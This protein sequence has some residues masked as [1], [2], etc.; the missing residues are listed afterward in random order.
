MPWNL[1]TLREVDKDYF[2]ELILDLIK[3]LGFRDADKIATSEETGADIIAIR[4]DPVSGLE[5]YLIKIKPRSLV[6]SS[7][8]NDFI[9]VLDRYKGDRG[10]FVTNVDFTKD[11]KLLAQREHRGRLIL[12]SGGKVVEMLN[13]YRIEPKKELIEKLKSK[14][15]AESKKR[16]I[17]KIIKLDSPLLFDFNHEKTVE[18]VIGKLSKEY[19]IKRALVSLKYLGVILSPAYIISWSCRTKEQKEAEIKD[20]AVVF[21]DGSIVIRTSEDER[22]KPTVS[23]ALLNNSSVIKCTEKTLEVGISPSEATLIAKSQLSKELNVSQSHIAISAKKKVYVPKKALLKLQIHKNEAEAEMDLETSEIKIK[24]SL[25]PEEMLVD[26][27]KEE[28]KRVTREELREYR[29]KIKEN[30]MLLRGETERFEFAVAIDGYTGEILAKDIRMKGEALLEL[31]SQLY[32]QGKLV[33][34]EERKREAVGDILVE[35]KIVILK[36]N[37]ENGEYSVLKELHH[38]E[39]AFKAAK[40]IIEDNFPVKDL[41]LENFKVLGHKVIEVLLSGEGGKARVKVDGTNLDVIDYFVEINQNKAKEL[42]LDKYKGCK[43]EEISED[44][45]SF[46]FSVS[47]D[48]QKIRVKISKDGK[49]I[50]ELDNVMKE[51]VVRE[52]ALKYLEEQG[53]EAKIEEITLDTDWIITFIG[54]EKFGKLILGRADGKVKAQE[55]SY[56]ERALEKFYYEHL[57]QKYGEENPATERMTHYRDKGYLTIKVSSEKKLYYAKI[58]VKTGRIIA[59]DTLVDKGITAKI[60]KMRLESRYK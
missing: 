32:P 46:T 12:W 24:I 34:V 53:V 3:N 9:R 18:K 25:L 58:D 10:I 45:D 31:I 2:I 51:E 38:P 40:A 60:K 14:K 50:E 28:C 22:L 42:I 20:K 54:D 30:R 6:S 8:L 33:N 39:E 52:K 15:E 19:K 13:E 55:I 4:E 41:K 57:K 35:N 59:E 21:S 56:T 7:D 49:L 37:L 29:T 36:V 17:L 5:K 11:A 1:E 16:A 48:T 27:A 43:I 23:K 44:S 47:S 26:F